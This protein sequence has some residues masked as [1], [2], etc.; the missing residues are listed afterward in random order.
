MF[1]IISA[2]TR[3]RCHAKKHPLSSEN[4]SWA[5]FMWKEC[6]FYC[7]LLSKWIEELNLF[8]QGGIFLKREPREEH[9][10]QNWTQLN[11]HH[12]CQPPHR[13][14][15]LICLNNHGSLNYTPLLRRGTVRPYLQITFLIRQSVRSGPPSCRTTEKNLNES[16]RLRDTSR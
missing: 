6:C 11:L 12:S 7:Q 16:L 5:R 3:G 8:T 1:G 15:Y 14:I 10:K 2:F 13:W 4:L 9:E